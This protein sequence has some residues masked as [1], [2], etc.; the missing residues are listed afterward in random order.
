MSFAHGNFKCEKCPFTFKNQ[1]A[2][3]LHEEEFNGI[4]SVG[5][6]FCYCCEKNFKTHQILFGHLETDHCQSSKSTSRT[7]GNFPCDVCGKQFTDPYQLMKHIE[8]H[9]KDLKFVCI[10]CSM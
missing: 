2:L 5:V 9:E 8:S 3:L 6:F 4:D 1:N 10:V 7:L